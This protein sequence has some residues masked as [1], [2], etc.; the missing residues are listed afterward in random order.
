MKSTIRRKIVVPGCIATLIVAMASAYC[1]AAFVPSSIRGFLLVLVIGLVAALVVGAGLRIL[2]THYETLPALSTLAGL[3]QKDLTYIVKDL[4][5]GEVGDVGRA[6][7]GRNAASRVLFANLGGN[8]ERIASGSVELS[9]TAEEMQ[10][11]SNEIAQVCERQQQGMAQVTSAMSDLS[12]LIGQAKDGVADSQART[13]QSA[14]FAREG[15]GVGQNASNSI[16]EIQATTKRMSKAVSVIREIAA[17]TNLLSLNAAIEAAKAGELGKGFAVVAEE[18][19]KLADRSAEATKEIIILIAEVDEAVTAGFESV[20]TCV[21][22]LTSIGDDLTALVASSAQVT[23]TLESQ[24]GTC[25]VV[26][27]HI[28]ATTVDIEHSVSASAEMS[29]TVGE[30]ARTAT[31]LAEVAEGVANYLGAY[32]TK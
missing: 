29:A 5:E 17:Q 6:L 7:N 26:R 1:G 23:E 21:E 8:A 24:V 12:D 3:Q 28:K 2:L 19:R 30:I 32:K 9:T 22:M 15:V 25:G 11:T 18:V 10:K 20:G 16:E 14:D 4:P 27:G 31:D 13:N